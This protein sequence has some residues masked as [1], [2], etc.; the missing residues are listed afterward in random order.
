[1]QIVHIPEQGYS[2]QY[3][4]HSVVMLMQHPALPYLL[5][6]KSL[7]CACYLG[8]LLVFSSGPVLLQSLLH[9]AMSKSSLYVHL[10]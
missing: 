9:I 2:F 5:N 8:T 10:I 4:C 3:F 6:C 1:M 7:A